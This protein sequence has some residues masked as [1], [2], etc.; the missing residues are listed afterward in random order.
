MVSVEG[1]FLR[2]KTVV[3]I[4]EVKNGESFHGR[5]E[6]GH[7]QE[8]KCGM[9]A[10]ITFSDNVDIKSLW[11][12]KIIELSGAFFA[13]MNHEG[14]IQCV[15][16]ASQELLEQSPAEMVGRPILDFIVP[17]EGESDWNELQRIMRVS[18]GHQFFSRCQARDGSLSP[19]HSSHMFPQHD[20]SMVLV[21]WGV[22]SDLIEARHNLAKT[23]L[24]LELILESVSDGIIGVNEAGR[25]IY[26][27]P[28]A[29]QLLEYEIDEVLQQTLHHI[30]H[31]SYPDGSHYDEHNCPINLAVTTGVTRHVSDEVFWNKWGKPVPV[32]YRCSPMIDQGSVVGAV[33]TFRDLTDKVKQRKSEDEMRAAQVIQQKLYPQAAPVIEKYEVYGT[34]VPA[35]EA[36]GDYYDFICID[37]NRYVF[38]VGD[39]TGHGLGPALQMVET[40]AILRSLLQQENE[41]H[42]AV[43]LLNNHLCED[44]TEG[45]FVSLFLA[46]LNVRQRQL[47][48]VGAGHGAL[49]CRSA[50]HQDTLES[51]G[52]LLGL[53]PGSKY[54]ARKILLDQPGDLLA[55]M[56][57][58]IVEAH[59]P[60]GKMFGEKRMSQTLIDN[61]T[62][63]CR[64]IADGVL[65]RAHSFSE[66][67]NQDD[68][69]I[70]IVKAT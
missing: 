61:R 14:T 34:V 41:L 51:T 38:A 10:N 55:I 24:N 62:K 1:E 32:D 59:S 53:L 30:L 46:E 47:R 50:G 69:T 23:N 33:V 18:P 63:T 43:E 40:R 4:E 57:D 31:H 6:V 15:S 28:T 16:S 58:G 44:L 22:T 68:M 2:E 8:G 56:T 39:V 54:E 60:S 9:G 12:K 5:Q 26:A 45:K 21:V 7:K 52:L 17:A 3:L 37:E 36:C 48:Y 20:D 65:A 70:V 66:H 42:V 25:V 13:V 64:E 35:C 67:Q 29:L 49:L 19:L 27:N 11:I